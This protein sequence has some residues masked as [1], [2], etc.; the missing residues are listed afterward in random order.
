[1]KKKIG[2]IISLSVVL[3]SAVLFAT[4]AFTQSLT[5]DCNG[6]GIVNSKDIILFKMHL[7]DDIVLADAKLDANGDGAINAADIGA[8]ADLTFSGAHLHDWSQWQTITSATCTE[9]GSMQRTCSICSNIEALP[10]PRTGHNYVVIE[11]KK[12]TC[13]ESGL[14]QSVKCEACG[15]VLAE[16]ET[17]EPIGAHV[18]EIDAAVEPT[19]DKSGLTEGSHCSVC[20]EIIIPQEKLPATGHI[21]GADGLCTV[22]G[23]E[24]QSAGLEFTV[25]SDGT[26]YELTDIGTATDENI[27]IPSTYN[28]L[29]V[30][31]IGASAFAGITE[32]KSVYIPHS[33]ETIGKNAFKGCTGL[34][35][36]TMC[37]GVTSIGRSAFSGCTGLTS[38]T[39]PDSV[40]SIGSYAFEGCTGL[41]SITIPGSVTSIGD[42]GFS[43]CTGLKSI[44]I[45]GS[46]TS[47]GIYAFTNCTGLTSVT[48]CEGVTSIGIYA[49][50]Y[51]T[52]LT[53]ITIPDSVTSIGSNAFSGCSGII[54]TVNGISY[55]DNWAIDCDTSSIRAVIRN[56]TVGIADKAFAD[57]AD[58]VKVTI[59]DSV[60]SIGSSAFYNCTGLTA[61]HISDIASWCNIA[62]SGY[63]SNPLYYAK[64][65][66]LNGELVTDHL[67]IPNGVTSIGIYA[68]YYCTGLTSITI[69]DSVTSIGSSAF[70]GCTGLTSITIPDS[71]TSI[72]SYA[73]SGCSGLTSI[74]IPDGVTSIGIY[75]FYYCDGLTS[76]TFENTVGWKAGSAAV[77]VSDPAANANYLKQKYCNYTWTRS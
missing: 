2:I 20:S 55:V 42:W 23:S 24:I 16:H 44:T 41:T 77:N 21:N 28:G 54:E 68:F 71:V 74:T 38:I 39:I 12:P 18:I 73:F 47:I 33:V 53:S 48:M 64:N 49:F 35:S 15:I 19:C 75:A 27:I 62:F 66:Y 3:V 8:M 63:Y 14:T 34:T 11:G 17:I 32:M 40:T 56:G 22:C 43:G 10:I 51:C 25:S 67:V 1:M 57:F 36:V 31:S 26:Y 30:K 45:P 59:P 70:S 7:N 52:G 58:L 6:D 69:P 76:V 9:Q 4:V 46:V 50:Y 37:E 61:V 60:T 72:G 29:P 13:T 65:L 5:G